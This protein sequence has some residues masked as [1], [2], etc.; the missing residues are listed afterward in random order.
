MPPEADHAELGL[1]ASALCNREVFPVAAPL[2]SATHFRSPRMGALWMVLTSLHK[3]GKAWNPELVHREAQHL[4]LLDRIEVVGRTS[5]DGLPNGAL[6]M[7]RFLDNAGSGGAHVQSYVELVVDAALRREAYYG[8]SEAIVRARDGTCSVADLAERHRRLADR[9]EAGVVVEATGHTAEHADAAFVDLSEPRSEAQGSLSWGLPSLDRAGVR[10]E[11]GSFPVLAAMTG[12]GKTTLATQVAYGIAERTA[13]PVLY[14]SLE[15]PGI[16][17]VRRAIVAR[18]GQP[19]AYGGYAAADAKVAWARA[20]DEIRGVPVY[21]PEVLDRSIDGFLRWL[22]AICRKLMPVVVFIDHMGCLRGASRDIY[23][24]VTEVSQRLR[25]WTL[26]GDHIPIVALAQIRR[27]ER[28]KGGDR[29]P[30]ELNDLKDSGS[31]EN[32]ATAVLMLDRPWSRATAEN[33]A[34]GKV[35]EAEAALYVKK[36]RHGAAHRKVAL[37]FDGPRHCIRELR[38]GEEFATNALAPAQSEGA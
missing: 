21:L 14:V 13:R 19:A 37:Y 30:P 32:D 22:S 6:D 1:V 26:Q 36:N 9:L 18:S 16:E 5:E 17:I 27:V 11:P 23:A 12:G 29:R 2:V 31:I 35:K 3:Q 15:M 20:R 7:M 33:R 25:T 34:K 28:Q 10:I 38:F 4:G 24:S 8:A